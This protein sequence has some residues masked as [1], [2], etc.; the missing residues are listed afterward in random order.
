[1]NEQEQPLEETMMEVREDFMLSPAGD[2]KPTLRTAH[3]LKPIQNTIDE[4]PLK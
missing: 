4:P 2:T 1:M 3:L